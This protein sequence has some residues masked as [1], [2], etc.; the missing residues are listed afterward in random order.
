MVWL[1]RVR[2]YMLKLRRTEKR[3]CDK[4]TWGLYPRL[5]LH[6]HLKSPPSALLLRVLCSFRL[7]QL[8]ILQNCVW[9]AFMEEG[10]LNHP[11]FDMMGVCIRD[12]PKQWR[13][14]VFEN[15]HQQAGLGGIVPLLTRVRMGMMGSNGA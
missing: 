2:T 15:T 11:R 7:L 8:H 5:H 12:Y 10:I 1:L 13:W 9:Y 3:G 14:R 4:G 6:D